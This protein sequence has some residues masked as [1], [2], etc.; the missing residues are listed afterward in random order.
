[1]NAI[2]GSIYLN[3]IVLS[4]AA[5]NGVCSSAVVYGEHHRVSLP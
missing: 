4:A 1:M 2:E 3:L 5:S